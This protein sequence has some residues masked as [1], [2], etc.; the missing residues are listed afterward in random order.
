VFLLIEL[1]RVQLKGLAENGKRAD[2]QPFLPRFT[3]RE[4]KELHNCTFDSNRRL[5]N[6]EELIDKAQQHNEQQANGPSANGTGWAGDIVL[7]ADNSAD[8]CIGR[9]L[10]QERDLNLDV[11][12]QIG[13]CIGV[14]EKISVVDEILQADDGFAVEVGVVLVEVKDVFGALVVVSM[15]LV[16]SGLGIWKLTLAASSSSRVLL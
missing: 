10:C 3:Q 13:V 8:F 9:V 11:G 15:R 6:R 1:A 12:N 14:L 16:L 4:R 7:V 2:G 5:T